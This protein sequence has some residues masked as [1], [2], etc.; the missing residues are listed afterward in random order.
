MK[1]LKITNDLGSS[2]GGCLMTSVL[3]DLILFIELSQ[4]QFQ[5]FKQIIN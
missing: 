1:A 2:M 4:W 5:I 3:V